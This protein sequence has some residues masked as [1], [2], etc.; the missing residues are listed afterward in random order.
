MNSTHILQ[1]RDESSMSALRSSSPMEVISSYIGP[2]DKRHQITTNEDDHSTLPPNITGSTIKDPELATT[3]RSMLTI[4]HSDDR[5]VLKFTT[6]ILQSKML[7][8][9]LF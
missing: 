2:R 5:A 3:S 4:P 7:K 8:A 9:N 1:A 6:R